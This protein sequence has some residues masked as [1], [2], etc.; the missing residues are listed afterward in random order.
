MK[1]S[2]LVKSKILQSGKC[3]MEIHRVVNV[4]L[5]LSVFFILFVFLVVSA[6]YNVNTRSSDM[7]IE[8]ARIVE[9]VDKSLS[10]IR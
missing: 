8:V 9:N 4:S 10:C 2:S 6:I 7:M 5:V 3:R 1:I